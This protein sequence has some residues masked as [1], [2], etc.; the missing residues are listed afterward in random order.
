[1]LLKIIASAVTVAV[2]FCLPDGF[3]LVA[4]LG[5][6]LLVWNSIVFLPALFVLLVW[7]KNRLAP[8][9][10]STQRAKGAIAEAHA[11]QTRF[12][13]WCN[14]RLK[15]IGAKPEIKG[16]EAE[17]VAKGLCHLVACDHAYQMRHNETYWQKCID[18]LREAHGDAS[19]AFSNML[20]IVYDESSDEMLHCEEEKRIISHRL[21]LATQIIEKVFWL[22][23]DYMEGN[24]VMPDDMRAFIAKCGKR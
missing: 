24:P 17:K 21:S 11:P 2:Y 6:G 4:K 9:P 5:I 15:D 3:G 14:F 7:K 22:S 1:M 12:E 13:Q 8:D 19:A 18:Q 20:F 16:M 10:S 23:I